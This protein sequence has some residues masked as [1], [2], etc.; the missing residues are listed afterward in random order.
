MLTENVFNKNTGALWKMLKCDPV[1][2]DFMYAWLEA[3]LYVCTYIGI[4]YVED[5]QQ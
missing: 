5:V 2:T 1:Y 4:I 3:L